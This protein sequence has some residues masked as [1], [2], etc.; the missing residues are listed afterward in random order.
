LFEKLEGDVA[1]VHWLL[2]VWKDIIVVLH[3]R[4]CGGRRREEQKR[5]G[6][7]SEKKSEDE[8]VKVKRGEV[9]TFHSSSA[10][11]LALVTC[12]YRS[13]APSRCLWGAASYRHAASYLRT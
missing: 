4:S 9:K 10:A 8:R 5:S 12:A 11:A 3:T 2:G 1:A 6:T 7:C 13:Q